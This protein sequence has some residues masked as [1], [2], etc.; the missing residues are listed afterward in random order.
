MLLE[1]A[2]PATPAAMTAGL[3]FGMTSI[4]RCLSEL[5]ELDGYTVPSACGHRLG[6]ML[7]GPD[8]WPDGLHLASFGVSTRHVADVQG[9]RFES[10]GLRL[11]QLVQR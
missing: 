2:S 7:G 3:G 10:A 6:A 1:V 4:K 8:H 9:R 5:G 11:M